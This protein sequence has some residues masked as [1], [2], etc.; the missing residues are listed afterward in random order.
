MNTTDDFS[1]KSNI[2]YMLSI[3][4]QYPTEEIINHLNELGPFFRRS[5]QELKIDDQ[6][7]KYW[8]Y[9]NIKKDLKKLQV[10]YTRLFLGS[11]PN[12]A[13][14]SPYESY[15]KQNTIMGS[16]VEKLINIFRESELEISKDYSDLPDHITIELTYLH[17]ITKK[18]TEFL[19]Q[20]ESMKV[21]KM[22]TLKEKFVDNHLDWFVDFCQKLEDET[23]LIFYKKLAAL[24]RTIVSTDL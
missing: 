22:I 18:I 8:N 5:L 6:L 2:Y 9:D 17:L 15:W 20:D 10:E 12:K 19:K 14:I 7:I 21:Q 11:P 24:T 4:Y 1:A 16:P 23:I 13:I 3:L